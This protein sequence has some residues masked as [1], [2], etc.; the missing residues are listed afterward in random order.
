MQLFL[1]EI[2]NVNL[3]IV[4]KMVNLERFLCGWKNKEY[5]YIMGYEKNLVSSLKYF[6]LYKYI[7]NSKL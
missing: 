1:Y 3:G 4:I 5:C 7:Y 6:E 2:Y